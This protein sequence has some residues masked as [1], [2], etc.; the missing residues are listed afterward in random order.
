MAG[1]FLRDLHREDLAASVGVVTAARVEGQEVRFTG[2]VRLA[3]YVDIVREFW[4]H[5]R[6]SLGFRYDPAQLK[7]NGDGTF[8][9]PDS[10]LVDHL[11][12]VPQGQY[13]NARLVRL[14]NQ[15]RGLAPF[16]SKSVF[17]MDDPTSTSTVAAS[18]SEPT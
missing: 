5:V 9:L 8:D 2:D 15:A 4:P 3:P 14:L 10:F 18:I 13:P 17:P 11:A 12:L 1:V 16:Q 7:A 6:F